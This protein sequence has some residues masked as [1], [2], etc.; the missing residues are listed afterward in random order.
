L[1]A[2]A[3][4]AMAGAA[5]GRAASLTVSSANLTVVRTCELTGYPNT[6]SVVADATVRQDR[7]TTNY[8]TSTTLAVRSATGANRRAYVRYDLTKCTSAIPASASVKS[9]RLS[10]SVTATGLPAACRTED[11]FRVTGPWSDSTITWATQPSSSAI[12]TGSA[13][14]GVLVGCPNST[15]LAYVAWDVTADVQSFVA[16]TATNN[17]W[18]IRDRNEDAAVLEA[19]AFA[20][21]NSGAAATAP[22]LTVTYMT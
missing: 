3:G 5:V 18:M 1:W 19:A 11:V 12:P 8:G 4:I 13:V 9:A 14:V 22:V 21:R 6:T 17:G 20:S 15:L 7:S 10:L 16:G 2:T